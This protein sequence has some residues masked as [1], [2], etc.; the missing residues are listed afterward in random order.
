MNWWWKF[1]TWF[2][3][4]AE[5]V[6]TVRKSSLIHVFPLERT[7]CRVFVCS[8]SGSPEEGLSAIFLVWKPFCVACQTLTTKYP[9]FLSSLEKKFLS[10]NSK[11]S[12]ICCND[13]CEESDPYPGATRP[14]ENL[15]KTKQL[16]NNV[17]EQKGWGDWEL[18]PEPSDFVPDALPWF[19][20]ESLR[21][22]E[23]VS[24]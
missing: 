19:P 23:W 12:F 8:F 6:H 3:T 1:F 4:P 11:I 15:L 22:I 5:T 17:K 21:L 13:N 18:N 14:S 9:F 7:R 20:C 24:N 10:V 2:P 16:K